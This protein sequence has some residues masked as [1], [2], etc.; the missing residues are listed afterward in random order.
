MGSA[1]TPTHTVI[2]IKDTLGLH[3]VKTPQYTGA[4]VNSECISHL[5]LQPQPG[6]IARIMDFGPANPCLQPHTD[7]P[8]P[9]FL[10]SVIFFIALLFCLYNK[11]LV[12]PAKCLSP[13][14]IVQFGPLVNSALVNS[15]RFSR[16][17][18]TSVREVYRSKN[19]YGKVRTR[20][21]Y[22]MATYYTFLRISL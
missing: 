7:R 13:R 8:M 22:T 1:W 17:V 16:M 12:S 2:V 19:R 15:D 14:H 6:E 3:A 4:L 10:Q 21:Q 11:S 20:F 9:F 5:L 18:M